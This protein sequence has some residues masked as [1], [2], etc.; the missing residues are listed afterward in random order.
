MA[1]RQSALAA[2]P[3][4]PASPGGTTIR[5][6]RPAAL[7]QVG[8]WPDTVLSVQGVLADVLRLDPPKM[9]M[10]ASDEHATVLCIGPGRYLVVADRDDLPAR[11]E[12]GLPSAEGAVADLS[13]GRTVLRL[14]G[15][16][17]A[18][19]LARCVAIDLNA[20][21]FPPGRVAQTAIHHVDV[22][23]CR[24]S[25]D[26]FDLVMLRGFAE[27]LVEWMLDAGMEFGV[28]LQG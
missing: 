11:L 2:L 1:E 18:A 24:R 6:M 22:T 28:R 15:P 19:V 4:S 20:R 26:A 21:V 10:A 5:E 14:Q 17:A 7:V 25:D 27:S 3:G 16:H 13:H 8:A 9:G 12:A 23:I